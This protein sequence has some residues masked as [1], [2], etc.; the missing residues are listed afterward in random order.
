MSSRR[1][2]HSG[3]KRRRSRNK[4]RTF[5]DILKATRLDCARNAWDRARRASVMRRQANRMGRF[6]SAS[7]LSVIKCAA[8]ARA[9][10][11][12]P[13]LFTFGF[14]PRM[15]LPSVICSGRGRLHLPREQRRHI[16]LA[17]RR[18]TCPTSALM[19]S[20][21]EQLELRN[22]SSN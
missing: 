7:R 8:V 12:A 5:S 3:S 17:R 2:K 1:C 18:A 21:P 6:K 15:S 4:H 16:S 13:E 19:Q 22:G 14:D 20:E 9:I 11:L 10:C